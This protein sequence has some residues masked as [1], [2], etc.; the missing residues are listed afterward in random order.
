MHTRMHRVFCSMA[1]STCQWIVRSHGVPLKG[2]EQTDAQTADTMS[3]RVYRGDGW[4][5]ADFGLDTLVL[6]FC[7]LG[8]RIGR[9][10]VGWGYPKGALEIM[11]TGT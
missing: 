11:V 1:T 9:R 4:I 7:C 8:L 2:G 6:E 3:T 5:V 10:N